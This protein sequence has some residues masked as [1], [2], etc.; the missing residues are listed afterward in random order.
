MKPYTLLALCCLLLLSCKGNRFDVPGKPDQP[1]NI[2][3][4]DQQF[5]TND[6]SIDSTFLKLYAVNIMEMGEPGSD[7]YRD[8]YD[9]Y[10]TDTDIANLYDSC[11][12]LFSETTKLETALTWAFHRLKHFFPETSIPTVYMHISGYGQSII[13]APGILSAS[14]DKYLGANHPM[15]HVLYEPHQ[16]Q[17]MQP[18]KLLSDYLLGWIQ[19][20]YTPNDL[21]AQNR[22]LDYVLYE[23]KIIFLTSLV[24]PEEPLERLFA[25]T[26]NQLE[27]CKQHEKE[28]WDGIVQHQFLFTTDKQVIS[29]FLEEAPTTTYFPKE[30]PGRAILW[31]GYTIIQRYMDKHPNISLQELLSIKDAQLLLNDSAYHP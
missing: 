5:H 17:R 15:Y 16:A 10:H 14:L 6:P 21:I 23:G 26:P 9:I 1:I 18:D 22:L 7:N 20:E 2:V 27:W 25:F 3:R 8:F 28:M 12:H 19:S 4:F 13:S 24:L 29:R 30:S 11:Q 31:L